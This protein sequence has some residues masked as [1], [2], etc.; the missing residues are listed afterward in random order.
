MADIPR[1]K[2]ETA[3]RI[4]RISKELREEGQDLERILATICL[5]LYKTGDKNLLKIPT[6]QASILCVKS[7][8]DMEDTDPLEYEEEKKLD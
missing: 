6:L 8:Y 1:L 5:M 4:I 7:Y 3:E 2:R